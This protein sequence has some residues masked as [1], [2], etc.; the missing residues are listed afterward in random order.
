MFTMPSLLCINTVELGELKLFNYKS[1][2]SRTF[3]Y[4]FKLKSQTIF[5]NSL[6]KNNC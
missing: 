3:N 1:W 4:N 2:I 5:L 6:L